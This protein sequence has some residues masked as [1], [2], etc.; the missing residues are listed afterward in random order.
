MTV[1]ALFSLA[2]AESAVGEDIADTIPNGTEAILLVAFGTSHTAA[3][4]AYRNVEETVRQQAPG[5]E[6][7]WAY[8][9]RMIRRIL[10][11]RGQSIDSPEE[12]LNR[13]A[14]D[15]Y[16][17]VTV[18]SLHVISGHEYGEVRDAVQHHRSQ[19]ERLILGAPLLAG[20]PD[21]ERVVDILLGSVQERRSDEAL[22]LMGHGSTH[23]AGLSY[24]ALDAML[25][26]RDPHAFLGTVEGS[27]TLS[28]VIDRCREAGIQSAVLLPFM[29]VA[30]DH[31]RNDMGGDEPDSW[32]S[33]L[34]EAGIHALP[35]FRG[36]A[37]TDGFATLF[38]EH[39]MSAR[40]ITLDE[41]QD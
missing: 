3:L 14:E 40:Q 7:R 19:F 20:I 32:K 41:E 35:I 30:G 21:A 1:I 15:G 11:R 34:S 17:R 9:S 28:Q 2:V 16:R 39:L 36:I 27:P 31:A 8:T 10:E 18:Q 5:V 25:R 37:E 13:L 6:I 38:V 12:A 33:R 4:G 29:V 26:D 22:I 24:V 23:A